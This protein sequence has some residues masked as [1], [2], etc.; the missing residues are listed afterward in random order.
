[1]YLKIQSLVRKNPA[2]RMR[3]SSVESKGRA[4]RNSSIFI[5]NKSN[6]APANLANWAKF[7]NKMN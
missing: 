2:S 7:S 6:L 4:S 1:M 3:D 5:A